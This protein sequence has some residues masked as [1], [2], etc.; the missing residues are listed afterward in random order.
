MK[1]LLSN[2][3]RIEYSTSEEMLKRADRFMEELQ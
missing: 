2:L 3:N 1:V